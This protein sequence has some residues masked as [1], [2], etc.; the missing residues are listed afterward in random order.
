MFDKCERLNFKSAKMQQ[1]DEILK[2]T[3]ESVRMSERENKSKLDT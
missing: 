1:A 3:A 2:L